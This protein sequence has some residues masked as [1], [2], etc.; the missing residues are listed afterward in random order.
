MLQ[1]LNIITKT[2]HLTITLLLI[3]FTT[4]HAALQYCKFKNKR[5]NCDIPTQAKHSA[6]TQW[7]HKPTAQPHSTMRKRK[8]NMCHGLQ[9]PRHTATEQECSH[10]RPDRSACQNFNNNQRKYKI[11]SLLIRVNTI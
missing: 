11:P 6:I 8:N 9:T 2:K 10:D 7:A 1:K 5:V 4:T 3:L